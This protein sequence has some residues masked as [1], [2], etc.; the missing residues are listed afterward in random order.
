MIKMK[1][2]KTPNRRVKDFVVVG[3]INENKLP[4][5]D[6]FQDPHLSN[7]FFSKRFKG[8]KKPKHENPVYSIY[9]SNKSFSPIPEQKSAV[10]LPSIGRLHEKKFHPVTSE[11]FRKILLKFRQ[12]ETQSK[13]TANTSRGFQQ[14]E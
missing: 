10:K 2:S 6:S 9:N 8:S 3:N 14:N 5:Y 4:V 13:E 1:Q 12:P 11:Q 7:F